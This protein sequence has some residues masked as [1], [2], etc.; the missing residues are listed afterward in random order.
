MKG[1]FYCVCTST[2]CLS[3]PKIIVRRDVEGSSRG[4]REDKRDI[5][6]LGF[7]VKESESSSGNPSDRDKYAVFYALKEPPRVKG[8]KIRVEGC[9]ALL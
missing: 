8:V 9:V 3:K 5:V 6:V 7:T 1:L 2:L 4:S